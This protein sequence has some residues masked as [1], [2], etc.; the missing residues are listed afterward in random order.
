MN[1]ALIFQAVS[2]IA[3]LTAAGVAF[4]AFVRVGKWRDSDD[5]KS[6]ASDIHTIKNEITRIQAELY[7]TKELKG[8]VERMENRTTA[9]ETKLESLASTA[10][11]RGLSAEIDSLQSSIRS[12]E[13]GVTRIESFLMEASRQ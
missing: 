9:I 4:A 13:A 3:A 12:T 10:D 6:V 1:L 2:M 11:I 7:L 8:K 5:G